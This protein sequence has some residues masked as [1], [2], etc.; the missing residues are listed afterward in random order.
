VQAADTMSVEP[1]SA[2]ACTVDSITSSIRRSTR[3]AKQKKAIGV[4]ESESRISQTYKSD[5]HSATLHRQADSKANK[6]YHGVPQKNLRIRF[7]V[8]LL[9]LRKHFFQKTNFCHRRILYMTS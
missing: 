2:S 4:A 1:D 8:T 7:L 3:I 6:P 5:V 9:S